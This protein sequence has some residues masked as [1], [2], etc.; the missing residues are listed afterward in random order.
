M[1]RILLTNARIR[2]MDAARPEAGALVIEGGR[3]LAIGSPDAMAALA[4]PGAGRID[5]GGRLVLPGLQDAHVHLLSGG[6]DLATAAQLHDVTTLAGLQD[7]LAVHAA[8]VPGMAMV[9]GAGWQAGIF[10]DHNLTAAVIDAVVPDRPVILYDSSYHNACLNT[11]AMARAG[12]A[13]GIADPPNGHFVTDAG[14]HPTGMLHEDAI[15]RVLPHLPALT[16][17]DRLAGLRAGQAHANALGI[18]GIIDPRVEPD[19]ARIYAALAAAGALTLH[20]CGAALVTAE[21]TVETALARLEAMRRDHAGPEFRVQSAKFFMDGVFE[22]RTAALLAPY[23][24][25]AGGNCATMF[26]EAQTRDLFTALDAARFQIHVHVIG[27]AA[28]RVALDGLA[29]ARAANGDWPALHQ[30]AHLQLVAPADVARIA[31]T[32]AMANIQ[33]LWA[34][35]DPVVPDVALEMIGPDRLTDTYAFRRM[36]DAGAPFCLSSDW[37]VTTLNP[38]EIMETAVTRQPRRI[39]GHRPPFLPDQAL[40]VEEAVLGYTAH[41]AAACWRGH[42]TGRLL[43]G[44]SADLIVLDQDVFACPPNR[45]GDTRVMLTLFRGREVHRA[46][47]FDG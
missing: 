36:L 47:S 26:S 34:R 21:D 11:A 4:G 3:I 28:A 33:P 2:T 42:H 14:G 9:I 16:D 12:V 32:G 31:A 13:R 40:T 29:A 1:T 27:D 46:V 41:A 10:G 24:D 23:A 19:D 6:T 20:V 30:L 43:P 25:T 37:P 15:Y 35:Y 38:F 39:E 5:A 18:T 8:R 22:N 45:I 44:F 7:R 17:A